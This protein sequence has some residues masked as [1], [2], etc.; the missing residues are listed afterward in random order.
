[1]RF[2]K[3]NLKPNLR[4]VFRFKGQ[5]LGYK[6]FSFNFWPDIRLGIVKKQAGLRLSRL[7][8]AVQFPIAVCI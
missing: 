8:F 5:V 3:F 2:F 4:F 1:M 7:I 6:V